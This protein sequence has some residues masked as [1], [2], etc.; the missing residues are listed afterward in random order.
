M[1]LFLINT[2]R[3]LVLVDSGAAGL[4]SPNSY[5]FPANLA[6]IGVTPEAIDD[7]IVTHAHPDHIG[8]LLND[9]KAVLPNARIHLSRFE[10][11]FWTNRDQQA[12]APDWMHGWFDV[13]FALSA[14]Y[15]G[16]INMLAPEAAIVDG[17]TALPFPGHTPGHTAYLVESAGERLLI[18][19]DLAVSTAIQYPHPRASMFFD[20]DADTGHASSLRGFDLAATDRLL[21]A[22]THL[23]FPTFGYVARRDGAHAWIAEEWH[24]DLAGTAWAPVI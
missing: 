21:T 5:H 22:G 11:D 20:V 3:R 19:G 15:E 1:T 7:V 12:R 17:I 14:A 4:F 24:H 9:G 2:G 8:G 10:F 6:Q 23:P 16:C 13:V 18:W